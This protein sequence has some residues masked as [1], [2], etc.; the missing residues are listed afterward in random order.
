MSWLILTAVGVV[1]MTAINLISFRSFRRTVILHHEIIATRETKF[2]RETIVTSA[3]AFRAG[4]ALGARLLADPMN[5]VRRREHDMPLEEGLLRSAA[6]QC[7][8]CQVWGGHRTGCT[9]KIPS[10]VHGLLTRILD[11]TSPP[12]ALTCPRC[13]GA[14]LNQPRG[15]CYACGYDPRTDTNPAGPDVDLHQILLGTMQVNADHTVFIDPATGT[16]TAVFC[17]TC[18]M[19]G[20]H[21]PD[22]TAGGVQDAGSD[23]PGVSLPKDADQG[24]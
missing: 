15:W 18:N 21:E 9:Q 5:D 2:E 3:R 13:T 14:T 11:L 8:E 12:E 22:C 19:L 23:P 16:M 4:V 6:L 10:D 20:G 24:S 7:D 17:T 1:F